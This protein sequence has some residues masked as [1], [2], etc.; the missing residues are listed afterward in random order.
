M[1]EKRATHAEAMARAKAPVAE[2]L[3]E[4][5]SAGDF[6][7]SVSGLRHHFQDVCSTRLKDVDLTPALLYFMLYIGKHDGCTQRQM[8]DALCMDVG[9]STRSVAKL[10]EAGYVEQRPNPADGR[11]SLLYLT[12][13]GK[14]AYAFG[15][16][17]L[18]E[19]ND[20][21]LSVLS[22]TEKELLVGL[23][24]RVIVGLGSDVVGKSAG[25]ETN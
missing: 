11:S 25:K 15:R 22:D 14:E 12:P 24:G 20:Q 8:T 7:L 2:I 18:V 5:A 19:W 21:V 3:E 1:G 4:A 10:V 17:I 6:A 13:E 16:R 9:Y 23:L